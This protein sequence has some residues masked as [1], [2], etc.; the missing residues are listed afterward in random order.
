MSLLRYLLLFG[1]FY[2]AITSASAGQKTLIIVTNDYP[3]YAHAAETQSFLPELFAEIGNKMGVKFEVRYFPWKRCEQE[4]EELRA[5]GAIPYRKTED[6]A[7]TFDF[8]DPIYVADSHFF[9]YRK[10]NVKREIQYDVLTDLRG[11]RIGGIQGYYYQPWYEAAGLDVDYALSEEQN[12]KR[13]QL[14]RIDLFST[15]TTVGWHIIK[16]LFPPEEVA[17]FYTLDTPLISGDGLFLMSSKQ[18]PDG[19]N[20][21]KRFNLALGTVKQDGTYGKLVDKYGLVLRY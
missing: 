10:D 15:A 3:P 18:Y 21:L 6:R 1:I 2:L 12:F 17:K 19:P 5:W 7:K 8:S 14:G 9:A 11:Y 13:L 20:L 16:Q 4:V